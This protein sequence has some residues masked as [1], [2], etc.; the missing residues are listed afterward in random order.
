MKAL[1]FT[2]V[3]RSEFVRGRRV[4]IRADLNVPLDS[5]G[6]IAEDTRIL[7]SLPCI[8]M[9]LEAGAAVMVSSHLGRPKEGTFEPK[10]SLAPVARRLGELL[11]CDVPLVSGWLDGVDVNA[12]QVV[13]LEN[14]RINVGEK[15][16]DLELSR[17][18]AQLCD[19]Y[20][21]DAFG[22]AHRAEA[23]TYGIAE[24]APIACVGPLLASEVEAITRALLSLIHI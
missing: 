7:A 23:T 2:D 24:F 13:L 11:G 8:R 9:A 12:G 20:V 10:D 19:V 3:A 6:R 1:R 14:C 5:Q 15:S 16:N 18:M 21:N 4:F 17:Q 22:T